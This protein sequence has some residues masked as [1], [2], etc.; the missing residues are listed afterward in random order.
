MRKA[1]FVLAATV[2]CAVVFGCGTP[3]PNTYNVGI[4]Y[5][6]E[7]VPSDKA[8]IYIFHR[9]SAVAAPCFV[10]ENTAKIGVIKSGTY[11]VRHVLPGSYEY[12]ATND[13]HIKSPIQ[14]RAE[15][16]KEYFLEVTQQSDFLMAH[17]YLNVVGKEQAESILPT[18]KRISYTPKSQ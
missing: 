4:A 9:A 3:M 6:P 14:I 2:V 7:P 8:T 15:A 5:S 17:P 13:S 12:M 10:H 18:L 1:I 11:F 16:G